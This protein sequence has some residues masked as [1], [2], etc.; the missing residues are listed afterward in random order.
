MALN[1]SLI[2]LTIILETSKNVWASASASKW[3]MP[4][5]RILKR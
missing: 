3:Q 5:I 1:F 2:Y 4:K